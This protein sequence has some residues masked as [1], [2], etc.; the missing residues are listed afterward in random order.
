VA[1][2]SYSWRLPLLA[3]VRGR[4]R[5]REP[6]L[7]VAPGA[8]QCSSP[9]WTIAHVYLRP[10][11]GYDNGA[12]V[13]QF[14]SSGEG[15]YRGMYKGTHGVVA[16]EWE[17]SKPA[18]EWSATGTFQGDSLTVEYNRIMLLTDF[19]DAVYVLTVKSDG[20]GRRPLDPS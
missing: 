3:E 14:T 7:A 4:R 16:F 5:Q 8:G 20:N 12:F 19:E 2:S 11:T 13:L 15:G 18:A 10:R 9:D 17:N 1:P 6:I